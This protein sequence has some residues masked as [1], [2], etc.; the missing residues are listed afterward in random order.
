MDIARGTTREAPA[1][2]LGRVSPVFL[3]L[4]AAGLA[5]A[6]ILP[7]ASTLS[8]HGD[9]WAYIVDR[10]L[11]FESMLRPHNEHL[12]FLHVLVYRGLV[13]AIGTSSYVPFLAVLMACHVAMSA[14]VFALMRR[15]VPEQG[16]LACA[17]LMLFLGSGFDNLVWA[18]QI[19]FV[20]AAA[21]GVWA[22]A[23]RPWVAAVLLTAALWTQGDGLFYVL[24]V[25]VMLGRRWW[26]VGFP[27]AIYAA[28]FLL[29][30][31]GQVTVAGP[32]LEYAVR[33]VGS[34]FGGVAGVGWVAGL[35]VLAAIAILVGIRSVG[36]G[37]TREAVGNVGVRGGPA[38]T[39]MS[40][41]GQNGPRARKALSPSQRESEGV[42][43]RPD[44][45]S[46]VLAGAAGILSMTLILTLSRAHFGP[47]QAE[48]PRYIYVGAPF[49]FMLLS[50]IRLPRRAWAVLFAVALTLNVLALPRG[51]A[52]YQAFVRYDRTVPL[53]VKLQQYR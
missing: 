20:G 6:V 9:E 3:F 23:S 8:F 53:E 51:V 42:P 29:T 45:S 22:M 16:A 43:R 48:A 1:L 41:I 40:P 24:P 15:E 13:E 18:F 31:R 33:L 5:V 32:F 47:E 25:A 11:T 14:G 28:W 49:V 38:P 19:G 52:I 35:A 50:G 17:V 46:Y 21:F 4:C 7:L 36:R 10:R 34:V 26:Y 37:D 12:V 30:D 27:L 2:R 39:W 44:F